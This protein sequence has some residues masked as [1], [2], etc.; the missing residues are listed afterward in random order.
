MTA[1]APAV[2]LPSE[3]W[4][5]IHRMAADTSPTVADSLWPDID[6]LRDMKQS[7]RVAYSF[8]LVS[9]L[10]NRLATE[11]L[12]ENIRVD[13]K[14][15]ALL[16]PALERS[17]KAKLVRRI[18]LSRD[19][20]DHNLAVLAMY[21]PTRRIGR[22]K[23][24]YSPD[25]AAIDR[26]RANLEYL[27]LGHS[28][29]FRANDQ[30]PPFPDIPSLRRVAVHA[31]RHLAF[32][33][34][35]ILHLFGRIFPFTFIFSQCPRLQELCYQVPS[36]LFGPK[37]K[38][39]PLSC[40]RLHVSHTLVQDWRRIQKHFRLFLSP[41]FPQIQRIV[42]HGSWHEVIDEALFAPIRD[43][44]RAQGCVLEFPEGCTIGN[45]FPLRSPQLYDYFPSE[46]SIILHSDRA[47]L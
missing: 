12:Y 36:G 25:F 31:T 47:S 35:R 6:P 7:W 18:Q 10:W 32:P 46:L 37:E 13:H 5:Y 2:S 9:R 43:G 19:R 41:A 40:I 4:L 17:Q 34:L 24:G 20:L 39:A 15:E 30:A 42:L 8:V 21:R 22:S 27:A 44:L 28:D 3:I 45:F 16:R 33:S 14:F 26:A 1:R 11:L 23:L 38:R 29:A